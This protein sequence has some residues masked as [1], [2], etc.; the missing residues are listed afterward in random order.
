MGRVT[1]KLSNRNNLLLFVKCVEAPVVCINSMWNHLPLVLFFGIMQTASHRE[2]WSAKR[3]I[4]CRWQK[5]TTMH[6]PH[7]YSRPKYDTTLARI[8]HL[9]HRGH[10]K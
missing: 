4:G 3:D 1:T 5:K 6:L 9:N 7:P 10:N 8:Q 2:P